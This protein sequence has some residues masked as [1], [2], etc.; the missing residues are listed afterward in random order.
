[1]CSMKFY[2]NRGCVIKFDKD[3]IYLKIKDSKYCLK[4]NELNLLTNKNFVK[5]I[6]NTFAYLLVLDNSENDEYYLLSF[7]ELIEMNYS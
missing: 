6:K 4:S 3:V 5:Y 7:K 2:G 1:M